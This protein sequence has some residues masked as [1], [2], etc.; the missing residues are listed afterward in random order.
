MEWAVVAGATGTLGSAISERLLEK[1]FGVFAVGRDVRRLEHAGAD[2][3][4]WRSFACDLSAPGWEASLDAALPERVRMV[5]NATGAAFGGGVLEVE[6][7]KVLAAV[8][9]KVNG[10]LRLVRTC[11]PHFLPGSRAV[12]IGGNLGLDPT[13]D[14]AVPGLVNAMLLAAVRQLN[15]ALAPSGVTAH[16]VAPGPVESP[17]MSVL[18]EEAARSHGGTVEEALARL[19]SA[20]PLG[21][22]TSPREVAWAVSLLADPEASALAGSILL[23]DSGQRTGIG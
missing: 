12:L 7:E 21:R 13:P 16:L 15:R 17:R 8:Q 23:L 20:A 18:A 10:S 19:R 2:R 1:G 14:S 6:P 11:R 5:V 22:L 3:A 9:L 4:G